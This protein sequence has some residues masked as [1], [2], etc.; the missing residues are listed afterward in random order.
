MA[1][2]AGGTSRCL[3]LF[4]GAVACCCCLFLAWLGRRRRRR[5]ASRTLARRVLWHSL[6]I[7]S[8]RWFPCYPPNVLWVDRP[9]VC[10]SPHTHVRRIGV[11]VLGEADL[12]TS[13]FVHRLAHPN[14]PGITALGTPM[15]LI[16]TPGDNTYGAHVMLAYVTVGRVTAEIATVGRITAEKDTV[17]R[18]TAEKLT[19]GHTCSSI[20]I[21]CGNS[22]NSPPAVPACPRCQGPSCA[23][24]SGGSRALLRLVRGAR[25]W[26]SG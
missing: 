25:A 5:V 17:G 20:H 14:N 6:T 3:G 13:R 15:G 10:W 2:D 18:I 19:V 4:L 26:A 22:N 12:D 8:I 9:L 24:S 1:A 16:A 21:S 11:Y 23:S 7:G